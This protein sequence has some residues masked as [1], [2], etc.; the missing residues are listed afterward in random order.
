MDDI[1]FDIGEIPE[2][3]ILHESYIKNSALFQDAVI[4]LLCIMG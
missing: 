2:L 1:L 3:F 4:D